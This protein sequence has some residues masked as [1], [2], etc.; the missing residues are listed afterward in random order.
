MMIEFISPMKFKKFALWAV[1][2]GEGEHLNG[3]PDDYANLTATDLISAG[4]DLLNLIL[5]PLQH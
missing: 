1:T 4:V 5:L 3:L 2:A